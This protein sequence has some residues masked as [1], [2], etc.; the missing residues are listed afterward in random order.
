MRR[1]PEA[2]SG[3]LGGL[4]PR[5]IAHDRLNDRLRGSPL[6]IQPSLT[7]PSRGRD[8]DRF[9]QALGAS[10]ERYGFAIVADHGLDPA[11]TRRRRSGPRPSSPGRRRSS[12]AIGSPGGAGPARL[13]AF[14]GRDRQGRGPRRP[15]GILA[16]WP[17]LPEGHPYRA[18]SQCLAGRFYRRLPAAVGGPSTRVGRPG[19]AAARARSP[20]TWTCRATTSTAVDRTAI[21]IL[22]LLH[23]PPT[24]GGP[25]HARR[26]A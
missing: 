26:R 5:R 19:S 9:A 15:E 18:L 17:R 23:Y 2:R 22:R 13:H 25:G 10:F 14:R 16:R 6:A 24:V 11:W 8:F 21:S 7:S 20:I 1:N 12:G 4:F 3:S